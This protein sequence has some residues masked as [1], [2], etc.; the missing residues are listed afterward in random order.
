MG[1]EYVGTKERLGFER[2]G[3]AGRVVIDAFDCI[4]VAYRQPEDSPALQHA[5]DAGTG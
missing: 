2:H 5:L 4:G 3:G 1:A